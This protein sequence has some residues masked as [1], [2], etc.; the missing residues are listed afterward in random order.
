MDINPIGAVYRINDRWSSNDAVQHSKR[1]QHITT[2]TLDDIK[3][4]VALK[5][6]AGVKYSILR[7][8][9]WE[10][11][12]LKG[13][14]NG[15]IIK[16]AENTYQD[17]RNLRQ[18][19]KDNGNENIHFLLNNEQ[20]W[21][22]ER[23]QFY[24]KVLQLVA[25]DK[26]GPIGIV[27][28]NFAS[29][30]VKSGQGTDLNW[31]ATDAEAFLLLL[32]KYRNATLKDGTHAFILGVHEYT[33]LFAWIAANSGEYLAPDWNTRFVQIDW[34]K[35][36][37]HLGRTLQGI[38]L[39]GLPVPWM[40]VTETLFDRMNDIVS[41]WYARGYK[42]EGTDDPRGY[43]SLQEF[44]RQAGLAGSV[45]QVY[46]D[47]LVWTWENVW[48]ASDKILGVNVYLFNDT[49]AWKTFDVA[50]D[51]DFR[52]ANA[53]YRMGAEW[54]PCA[55]PEDYVLRV[56]TSV[57]GASCNVRSQPTTASDIIG[58]V[59]S[60][61]FAKINLNNRMPDDM[62]PMWYWYE[63][64]MPDG[65]GW[66]SDRGGYVKFELEKPVPPPVDV[67]LEDLLA[68]IE[69]LEKAPFVTKDYLQQNYTAQ[70]TNWIALN[71]LSKAAFQAVLKAMPA[72][73]AELTNLQNV[74]DTDE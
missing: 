42:V 16:N 18:Q 30:S 14:A 67:T 27:F 3:T 64:Q 15:V 63:I 37:W 23:L 9:A 56:V 49:G 1:A 55:S 46:H 52:D 25:D 58:I 31:W 12:N 44:W 54:T 28:G 53:A 45:G 36:Q 71:F 13:Q 70:F 65:C 4:A 17:L 2:T 20:E 19:A 51:D 34:S 33:S 60:N 22:S 57:D 5:N 74:E 66:I 39:A 47:F 59:P 50:F 32:E 73:A 62:R 24:T 35:N 41:A 72:V 6:E 68:R 61:S 29:G 8:S 7:V 21:T 26:D 69:A 10:P 48:S 43:H 38:R 11:G 40:I